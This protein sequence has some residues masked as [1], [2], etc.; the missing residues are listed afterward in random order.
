MGISLCLQTPQIV[1]FGVMGL[2]THTHDASPYLA[3]VATCARS[4]LRD[5]AGSTGLVLSAPLSHQ[6]KAVKKR[7]LDLPFYG[8]MQ[9][10][11]LADESLKRSLDRA[12]CVMLRITRYAHCPRGKVSATATLTNQM[13][14]RV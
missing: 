3:A 7:A 13:R 4:S 12:H 14:I 10:R 2:N 11:C 8:Q 9:R 5:V 1:S 6:S